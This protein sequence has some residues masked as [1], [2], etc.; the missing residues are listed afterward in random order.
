[1]PKFLY[2]R[3]L[4]LALLLQTTSFAA[5]RP[6][7]LW[8]VVDDMSPNFSC[9]GETTITTP[10]VDQLATEGT[11]FTRAYVTAPV[12]SA[13]RSGLI[14]GMYQT[15]IGAHHHRSGRG[16]LKITLPTGVEPLP[17]LFQRAGYYTCIGSGLNDKDYRG[18]P[19]ADNRPNDKEAAKGTTNS[20][21]KSPSNK[22]ASR[23]G[24]TD[25]NFE[26]NEGIYDSHDWSNRAQDQPFFM[27]VQLHG[28]KLREGSPQSNSAFLRRVT[29]ELGSP[30]DPVTVKLPPYYPRD[31][32]LLE[33]WARYLDS[34]RLTDN[35]VGQVIARLKAEGLY[36]N[37]FIVFMTDHGI[38]HARGKQFLYD[39]G[40][41]IPF[42][43]RGPGISEATERNDLVEHTD[44]AAIS[45]A[46]AGIAIPKT[47]QGRDLF[48]D[49]YAKRE[50][51]YAA[52]DRC[53]ETVERIRSV[54]TDKF[55]YIRNYF[56]KRPHLQ[57]NAYKDGK[58]IIQSLRASH[59]VG[60]L[61]ELTERL[62]FSPTRPTEELYLYADDR[63]QIKNLAEDTE[64]QSTLLD[65]RERLEQWIQT[66]GDHGYES[67]A[68]F[69]S[70]MAAYVGKGNPLVEE[71]IAVMKKWAQEGK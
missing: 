2:L 4:I 9:Y 24:K 62:L 39:E 68:M 56:P 7:I 6:N 47:M 41:H 11:R 10:H 59:Q 18:L 27:Q 61:P 45:L 23:L 38:S 43:V 28:G 13:C 12:C 46:A 1:M 60:T 25:Y 17:K 63:W 66:S 33:D 36:E 69:E 65:H 71:N 48:A 8:F 29:K 53:D 37:T 14:T 55:L 26:W 44:M 70:D 51:A 52:R 5:N 22:L 19:F 34:V 40:T 64:F 30:V 21:R 58:A 67:E 32:V 57:P 54:R 35:H 31:P 16:K 42:I 50:A 3:C 15:T 49:D 20:K